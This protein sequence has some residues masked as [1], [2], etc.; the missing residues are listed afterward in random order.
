MGRGQNLSGVEMATFL[1]QVSSPAVILWCRT[2]TAP[3][4][5][6]PERAEQL[7]PESNSNHEKQVSII[8]IFLV[9]CMIFHQ[10]SECISIKKGS[11][12]SALQLILM[13]LPAIL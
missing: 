4:S 10:E 2:S 9:H 6:R 12:F 11:I 7:Q 13:T 1:Y 8:Q 5:N 3:C